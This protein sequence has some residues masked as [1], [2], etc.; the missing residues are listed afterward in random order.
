MPNSYIAIQQLHGGGYLADMRQ[1]H[2]NATVTGLNI[3]WLDLFFDLLG[4]GSTNNLVLYILL[5]IN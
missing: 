4:V 2:F 5:M 1:L 3:W